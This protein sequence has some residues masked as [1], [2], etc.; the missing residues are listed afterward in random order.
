M[1]PPRRPIGLRY[2]IA[3]LSVALA[4]ALRL[5]LDPLLGNGLPFITLFAAV[6]V[7]SWYGGRGTGFLSIL[8]S[9]LAADFFVLEPR[10]SFKVGQPGYLASAVLFAAMSGV[11]IM[12]IHALRGAERRAERSGRA[13]ALQAEERL[14]SEAR[15]ETEASRLAL[16]L[17]AGR[18]GVWEWDMTTNKVWW[19]DN[20]EEI[21]GLPRGSFEGTIEGF[22]R[23]IHPDDAE[24]VA[25]AIARAVATRSEYDIEFRVVK[26]NG[27]YV[28]IGGKGKVFTDASGQPVRM[29]GSAV[30]VTDR[31]RVNEA[32]RA[33]LRVSERLNS[34][35]DV[36]EML[37]ALVEEAMRLIDAESGV[38]GLRTPNGLVCR[39]Y[40]R[41]GGTAPFEYFWSPMVGLPGWV[42]QHKTPYLTNDAARDPQVIPAHCQEFSIRSALCVPILDSAGEVLGF[43]EIHNKRDG[44]PI[45]PSSQERMV[46]MA[47]TAGIAI[48]NALAYRKLQDAEIALKEADTRKDAFLATLAHELRN[49]LAPITSALE[50]LRLND[51]SEAANGSDRT[52]RDVMQRQVRHMVRLIDDLMDVSR[53]TRG[54]LELRR[55]PVEL[56]QVLQSAIETSGPLLSSDGRVF[57]ASIPEE[58]IWLDGDLTRL[59][60]VFSNLLN[61]AAKF[62]RSGGKI[63]LTVGRSNGSVTVTVADDGIGIDPADRERLFD[64]FVQ[65]NS[66]ASRTQTGLGIGLALAKQ[67]VEMHGGA[68]EAKSA[69]RDQGSDFVV[70]LPL[71]NPEAVVPTER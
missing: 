42:L 1:S 59:A 53:I 44:S 41:P 23:I 35:L 21:H 56:A 15:R 17:E 18:L 24:S 57:T 7:S 10:S 3:V 50:I 27:S 65:V 19:S 46:A 39:C 49:P 64:L 40:R 66:P 30:D 6:A 62:T 68:L 61:N 71:R 36:D 25:Q 70:R 5:S 60:Q 9:I 58:P 37:D 48:Q 54:K 67:L 12:L 4:I 16:A 20:L 52:A 11:I 2:V 26:P 69:G 31:R 34:T 45:T 55:A 51:R 8:L 32:L 29:V 28:W 38:A 43:F 13:L 47:Q 22:H 14:K 33:L 63:R